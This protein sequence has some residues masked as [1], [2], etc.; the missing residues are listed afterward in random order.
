[1]AKVERPE[2]AE[3]KVGTD[4]DQLQDEEVEATRGRLID[5]DNSNRRSASERRS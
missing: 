2:S 3:N 1:M 5:C 4:E